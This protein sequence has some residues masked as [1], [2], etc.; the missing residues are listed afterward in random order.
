MTHTATLIYG[1]GIGPEVVQSA[2]DI[3]EATR[4]KINFDVE[5]LGLE[6]I[7]EYNDAVPKKTL[8]SIKKNTVALKGPTTT[9]VASGHKS[10]NV[11][12]RKELDLYAC[13]RPVKSIAGLENKYGDVDLVVIRE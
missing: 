6:A 4:V 5:L 3:I 2:V 7:K 9:P 10:A 12:L 13:I 1:D 8:D 11:T